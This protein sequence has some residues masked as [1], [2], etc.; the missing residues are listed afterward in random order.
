VIRGRKGKKRKKRIILSLDLR[1]R[2]RKRNH[3]TVWQDPII[4]SQ[5]EKKRG[6]DGR[7]SHLLCI[8]ITLGNPKRMI[9]KRREKKKRGGA[10]RCAPPASKGKIGEGRGSCQTTFPGKRKRATSFYPGGRKKL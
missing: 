3:G 2:R 4:Y 5:G 6:K 9:V 10:R 1:P 7:R 8:P